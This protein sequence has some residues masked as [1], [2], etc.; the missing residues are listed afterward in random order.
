MGV[1]RVQT[2]ISLEVTRYFTYSD[3]G[4][5]DQLVIS[6]RPGDGMKILT[7]AVPESSFT[8]SGWLSC[9]IGQSELFQVRNG[10]PICRVLVLN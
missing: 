5:L 9:Q 7:Q 1:G 6:Y 10:L 8:N 4:Y 2:R 3:K